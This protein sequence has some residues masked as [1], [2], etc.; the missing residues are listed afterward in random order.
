MNKS[1]KIYIGVLT[2]V[3]V[4]IILIDTMHVKPVNWN[5]TYSLDT[6]NP[7][8]L[9]V[10]NRELKSIIPEDRISRVI[11]TPY[12]YISDHPK[13]SAYLIIDHNLF[14]LSDTILLS[15]V[16]KGSILFISTE[17]I[18]LN[19]T[20]S[21]GVRYMEADLNT[22]LKKLKYLQLKLTNK[23]WGN[24]SVQ[25]KPVSN[26]FSYQKVNLE[27]TTILGTETFPDGSVYP[28]FVKVRY[29]KG[30]VFLHCQP[31]AF[32][33]VAMLSE[34]SSS[35]YVAHLLSYL[36]SNLPVVWFVNGQ[37]TKAGPPV[38]ETSLS[39]VFQNPALR[40]VWL[41]MIYGLLLYILFNAKRRQRIIPVINPLKNTNVEF[42]QTIGNLYFLEGDTSNIV[43]KKIIYFLDKIRV[44][45]YLD[46]TNLDERFAE[47]LKSKS[48]K[49]SKLIGDILDFIRNFKINKTS[50]KKDL[51]HLNKLIEAFWKENI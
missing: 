3:F 32:T 19:I 28:N 5:P 31:Q 30:Y 38:S 36:P 8:D 21:L 40:A 13:P 45:Y 49:D 2:L 9:Y 41:I 44:K 43:E 11:K 24:S 15:E 50:E 27:T 17:S 46:T 35:L 47:R 16:A 20:D 14:T 51:I 1:M 48:G 33:N 39:V 22:T 4:V 26:T 42:I 37:T 6:K 12:E 10:F 23:T 25:L 29:G 7:F 34:N 18:A